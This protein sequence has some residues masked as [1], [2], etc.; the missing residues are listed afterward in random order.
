[1]KKIVITALL[2]MIILTGCSGEE[3]Q[4]PYENRELSNQG[5]IS[6]AEERAPVFDEQSDLS[7]ENVQSFLLELTDVESVDNPKPTSISV[8]IAGS[9][10]NYKLIIRF[11]DQRKDYHYRLPN[12][13]IKPL[14]LNNVYQ[15]IDYSF[16]LKTQNKNNTFKY[17][18]IN[19]YEET[20]AEYQPIALWDRS[21][22]PNWIYTGE[23]IQNFVVDDVKNKLV[24]INHDGGI[25]GHHDHSYLSAI[26]KKT[27]KET[28]SVYAGYMG[29]QYAFGK[30]EKKV[31]VGVNI[32]NYSPHELHCIDHTTGRKIW[33]KKFETD[34]LIYN[35]VSVK[36]AVVVLL[37][38]DG[39]YKLAAFRES[40]GKELW[41]K[42]LINDQVYIG[43][44]NMNRLILYNE[45]GITAYDVKNMKQKWHIDANLW[46][47]ESYSLN[48]PGTIE[49]TDPLS[50]QAQVKSNVNWFATKDG[51]IQVNMDNGKILYTLSA[52]NSRLLLLDKDHVVVTK[53]PVKNDSEANLRSDSYE[54]VNIKSNKVL[55]SDKGHFYGGILDKNNFVHIKGN[56]IQSIERKT[57]KLLWKTYFQSIN[58][59]FNDTGLLKPVVVKNLLII[60]QRDHLMVFNKSTGETLYQVIDYLLPESTLSSH[61][62][63]KI[64]YDNKRLYISRMNHQ[65]EAL[66]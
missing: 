8:E 48:H 53:Y 32:K 49:A 35:L 66:R 10:K 36:D 34:D 16:Y 58:D 62:V 14:S 31:F 65:L 20:I 64:Y 39:K 52:P 56:T 3:K 9:K 19:L 44:R 60:P 41:Q 1:M 40:D 51:F 15:P 45:K 61:K 26:D 54:V 13:I 21:F 7:D 57:G 47:K 25:S 12:D 6:V 4:L 27:G 30:K 17:Y 11:E 42:N 2:T 18:K 63:Y 22:T 38:N 43:T 37:N 28:W 50:Y 55:F 24:I 23:Q 33:T 46:I 59:R 29:A 5:V